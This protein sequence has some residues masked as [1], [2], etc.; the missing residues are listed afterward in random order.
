MS[1]QSG[2]IFNGACVCLVNV[3]KRGEQVFGSRSLPLMH[4]RGVRG[5]GHWISH[6][7]TASL[8]LQM[9]L[10]PPRVRALSFLNICVQLF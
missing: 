5:G 1:E 2:V 3:S 9:K 8:I 4:G 6:G 7:H 10:H